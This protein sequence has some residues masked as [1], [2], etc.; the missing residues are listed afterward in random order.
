MAF[1]ISMK[2][3]SLMIML[4]DSRSTLKCVTL[5]SIKQRQQLFC[6]QAVDS[7]VQASLI[8]HYT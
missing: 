8:G 5:V 2:F 7:N 6:K 1:K 3:D 4:N